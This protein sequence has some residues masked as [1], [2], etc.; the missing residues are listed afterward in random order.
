MKKHIVTAKC[1]TWSL[2]TNNNKIYFTQKC[3]FQRTIFIFAM[4]RE[5]EFTFWNDSIDQ[6]QIPFPLL[7]SL[8]HL[9][10]LLSTILH[11]FKIAFDGDWNCLE[12]NYKFNKCKIKIVL[13]IMHSFQNEWKNQCSCA[14]WAHDFWSLG[15]RS[16]VFNCEFLILEQLKSNQRQSVRFCVYVASF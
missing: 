4:L 1:F 13:Y 11:T 6:N 15:I 16:T 10:Y 5:S 8:L 2:F 14:N 9:S 7:Y 12:M 3:H